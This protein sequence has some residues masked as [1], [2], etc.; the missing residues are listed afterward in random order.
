MFASDVD[1]TAVEWC[2]SHFEFVDCKLNGEEPPLAYPE[3]QFDLVWAISVFTHLDEE[4]QFSWLGELRR[5]LKPEGILLAT[6]H[7]R[8]FWERLPRRSVQETE[9]HGFLYARTG[10]DRGMLPD[11][12]QAAWHTQEYV[13]KEWGRFFDLLDYLPRGMHD[14]QDLVV[15]QRADG[16]RSS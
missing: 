1:A 6:T 15:L 3:G 7:G 8:F 14:R 2:Q 11:W 10:V 9:A 4:R 13:G 5:I 12:Y 16:A